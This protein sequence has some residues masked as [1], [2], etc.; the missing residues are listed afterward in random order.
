LQDAVGRRTSKK[1]PLPS[2]TKESQ[3]LK[4]SS[5]VLILG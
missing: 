3:T 5:N 4:E 2:W 1:E